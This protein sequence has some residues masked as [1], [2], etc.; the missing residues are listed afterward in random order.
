MLS[1]RSFEKSQNDLLPAFDK[2]HA[3]HDVTKV[4]LRQVALLLEHARATEDLDLAEKVKI[5]GL[6]AI[7]IER[8]WTEMRTWFK[9]HPERI[10]IF[11]ENQLSLHAVMG[12][13]VRNAYREDRN[14]NHLVHSLR[15]LTLSVAQY[16]TFGYFRALQSELEMADGG[17]DEN[18]IPELEM[19]TTRS[20]SSLCHDL[21]ELL[22]PGQHSSGGNTPAT[23]ILRGFSSANATLWSVYKRLPQIVKQNRDLVSQYVHDDDKLEEVRL[24]FPEVKKVLIALATVH[25]D[26]VFRKQTEQQLSTQQLLRAG[27][28]LKV[29][30][31]DGKIRFKFNEDLE[32]L[33]QEATLRNNIVTGCPALAAI[34]DGGRNVVVAMADWIEGVAENLF[35]RT[36]F[37]YPG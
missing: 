20:L 3:A 21:S 14:P 13:S 33:V 37:D 31:E 25:F 22:I 17:A 9:D 30:E 6:T 15:P 27:F 2:A 10:G 1:R 5:N 12:E 36:I 29:V 28:G 24:F 23:H 8:I 18:Y 11:D 34:A 19:T 32:N 16:H 7:F 26:L 4:N 35:F